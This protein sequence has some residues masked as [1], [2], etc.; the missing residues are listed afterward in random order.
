DLHNSDVSPAHA[1][2]GELGFVLHGLAR[3][4]VA[5]ACLWAFPLALACALVMLLRRRD[6][7]LALAVLALLLGLVASLVL[8]YLSAAPGVPSPV[9]STA[10]RTLLTPTLLAPALLPL[11]AT[12]ALGADPPQAESARD[13]TPPR[14]RRL[15]RRGRRRPEAA[16][17]ARA[18]SS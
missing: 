13:R 12:R 15:R 7:D 3:L 2:V 10:K 17:R 1:H 11:L 16:A 14:A 6:R 8:V 18:P 5:Q 4:V 9:R